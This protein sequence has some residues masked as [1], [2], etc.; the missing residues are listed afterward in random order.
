MFFFVLRVV[1]SVTVPDCPARVLVFVIVCSL[2][3]H[4]AQINDDHDGL[5]Q[6]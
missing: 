6:L 1:V 4:N 5:Y 2:T 3:V